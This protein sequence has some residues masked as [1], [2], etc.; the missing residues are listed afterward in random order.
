MYSFSSSSSR[1]LVISIPSSESSSSSCIM[2][3]LLADNRAQCTVLIQQ[4][5]QL[6]CFLHLV[7]APSIRRRLREALEVESEMLAHL[8]DSDDLPLESDL[9]VD[10]FLHD[11]EPLVNSRLPGTLI[12]ENIVYLFEDPRIPESRP[13]YHYIV[14]SSVVEKLLRVLRLLDASV[15][16]DWYG[17]LRLCCSDNI[18]ALRPRAALHGGTAM[19]RKGC[20]AI[21]LANS[22]NFLGNVIVEQ[23]SLTYFHCHRQLRCPHD[24]GR[25]CVDEGEIPQQRRS[26]TGLYDFWLGASHIDVDGIDPSLRQNLCSLC[27]CIRSRPKH[28]EV[29]RMLNRIEHQH[30]ECLGVTELDAQGRDHLCVYH[31]CNIVPAQNAKKGIEIH[32]KGSK[33][34]TS[35]ELQRPYV[36]SVPPL[37]NSKRI[38]KPSSVRLGSCTHFVCKPGTT[39][40]D[41]PPVRITLASGQP[42]SWR[43]RWIMPSTI[44]IIPQTTPTCICVIVS[45]PML[46]AGRSSSIRG[47]LAVLVNKDSLELRRPGAMDPPRY[48]PSPVTKLNVVAVPRSTIIQGP[49]YFMYPPTQSA[50]RSAPISGG[51]STSHLILVFSVVETTRGRR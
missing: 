29:N 26:G 37:F 49:P 42:V 48:L 14:S 46:V 4:L 30:S 17:R 5:L 6:V 20:H 50:I 38:R 40:P 16:Y 51:D 39:T 9:A 12:I 7:D 45:I 13:P 3:N 15:R 23:K 36:H 31:G 41:S 1:T 21:L 35:L 10:M 47:N 25:N 22:Q 33:K 27:H 18:P 28:L 2:A 43:I 32:R 34:G 44:K 11:P 19:N 8:L 24:G